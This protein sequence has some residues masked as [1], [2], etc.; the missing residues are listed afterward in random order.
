MAAV[1]FVG[2][3]RALLAAQQFQEAVKACRIGLLGQPASVDG[4]IVLGQAL[5][6]LGRHDEA[7]AEMHA[8]LGIEPRNAD[9]LALRAEAEAVVNAASRAAAAPVP[10]PKPP[11]PAAS[12]TAPTM[13]AAPTVA[14]PVAPAPRAPVRAP[15]EDL[16]LEADAEE[17]IE[18]PVQIGRGAETFGGSHVAPAT[19]ALPANETESGDDSEPTH[20]AAPRPSLPATITAAPARAAAAAQAAA[21]AAEAAVARPIIAPAP[22]PI[23]EAPRPGRISVGSLAADSESVTLSPR[24]APVRPDATA[25]GHGRARPSSAPPAL[26]SQQQRSAAALDDLFSDL[27]TPPPALASAAPVEVDDD[28]G[29]EI[30]AAAPAPARRR[31][32][33]VD[34][35]PPLAPMSPRP[36]RSSRPPPVAAPAAAPVPVRP[37]GS[38]RSRKQDDSTGVVLRDAVAPPVARPRGPAAADTTAPAPRRRRRGLRIAL[39]SGAIAIVV[40]G[41]VVGGLKLRAHRLQQRLDAALHTATDVARTDT[42]LGWRQSRDRLAAV[43]ATR[44]SAATRAALVRARAVLAGEFDDEVE[45][46]RAAAA[47]LPPGVDAAISTAYVAL[48]GD[49]S[50]AAQAAAQ[51]AQAAGAPAAVANYLVG[52]AALMA[53]QPDAAVAAL[54]SSV[55][56]E[57]RPA[58]LVALAR[59]QLARGDHA[60]ASATLDRVRALAPEQPA[61]MLARVTLHIDRGDLAKD[62]SGAGALA[63]QLVAELDRLRTDGGRPAAVQQVGVSPRQLA[64]VELA[65]IA[66]D[67]ARG[68]AISARK[69][70]DSIGTDR[71]KD[72]R[73]TEQFVGLLFALGQHTQARAEAEQGLA[74]FPS[75]VPLR[76]VVA[77][78][79]F[80]DHDTAGVLAA[81][82]GVADLAA[83]PEGLALRGQARLAR[84][85]LAGARA[86]LDAALLARPSMRDA[87]L[88]RATVDLQAGDAAAARTRLA[89][90][91]AESSDPDVTVV[92]AA[93]LRATGERERA[94]AVLQRAI[95]AAGSAATPALY[96]ELGRAL[97]DGGDL[98]GARKAYERAALGDDVAAK[99]EA[100]Q[101]FLGAG[102]AA[103]ARTTL[104]AALTSAPSDPRLMLDAVR[105]R[106]LTGDVDGAA[107]LLARLPSDAPTAATWERERERGRLALRAGDPAAAATLLGKAVAAEA[108]LEAFLLLVDAQV[109]MGAM[110]QAT[111]TQ[112]TVLARFPDRPERFIVIGRVHLL[113]NRI[114]DAQVAFASAR[115]ELETA[116]AEPR[117]MA[118]A[119]LGQAQTVAAGRDPRRAPGLFDEATTLDPTLVEAWIGVAD[120]ARDA[121]D[122]A[123][124]LTAYQKAVALAPADPSLW[125]QIGELAYGL[126]RS[127]DATVALEK[128]LALAPSGDFAEDARTMLA[129][130]TRRR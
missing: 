86:D 52:R 30:V 103:L 22:T 59:A 74:A 116:K 77:A 108:D 123:A 85:D 16:D 98:V 31:P 12:P 60:A 72:R 90:M 45:V 76:L 34:A 32:T 80:H 63:D 114:A 66:I 125:F 43:V 44:D 46:A 9:A 112:A 48:A 17:V 13:M 37:T 91:A 57:A 27:E 39:W 65:T 95:D 107:E 20:S 18:E 92:Y 97:K 79:A 115:L 40:G 47:T 53:N 99:R 110:E 130:K 58:T 49:D 105:L 6:K 56:A 82:D 100:A 73:F 70:L 35:L 124:A 61:A 2:K 42:W 4:R 19:A 118:I 126:R 26:N 51:A 78:A 7:L 15:T 129:G 75:S 81:L 28:D 106:T 87:I 64:D 67:V 38:G 119:V 104:E 36:S 93:A 25:A 10:A 50:G 62:A 101:L 55:D 1:D 68:D 3:A 96:L 88:G 113:G 5:A 41:G 111:K 102:D 71:P 24:R 127:A 33:P 94:Q 69:R 83:H 121:G 29:L 23:A 54:T 122:G 109:L 84:G 8:V 128:Y 11:V 89:A 14:R 21:R 120:L 117:R